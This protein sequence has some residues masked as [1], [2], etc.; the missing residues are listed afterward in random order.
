MRKILN[1]SN[2]MKFNCFILLSAVN[3]VIA[4][5]FTL[6][7]AGQIIKVFEITGSDTKMSVVIIPFIVFFLAG[8]VFIWKLI[9]QMIS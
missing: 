9:K 7:L 8:E 2:V 1:E 5:F 3:F 4:V 6:L